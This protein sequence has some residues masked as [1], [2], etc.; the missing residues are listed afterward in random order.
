MFEV[1]KIKVS[2]KM[3]FNKNFNSRRQEI[4]LSGAKN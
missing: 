1:N 3:D 4:A 2:E